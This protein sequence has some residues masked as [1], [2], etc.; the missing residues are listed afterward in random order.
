[1]ILPSRCFMIIAIDGPG[2]AGKSSTAKIIAEKLGFLY[3]D[4]GAMYRALAYYTIELGL[5]IEDLTSLELVLSNL[6]INFLSEGHQQRL[7]INNLDV[8]DKIRTPD[9]SNLASRIATLRPVR[10]KLVSLQRSLAVN[11]HVIMDGRDIGTVVFPNAEVK[12]YLTASVEERS[13]RRYR[14]MQEKG[15]FADLAQI[16]SDLIWRDKNDAERTES[17]LRKAV[18]AIALD[19]TGMSVEKQVEVMLDLIQ[20]AR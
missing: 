14:E 18:D 15:E 9:V 3:L 16:T 11:N 17:P 10:E 5:K 7:F 20:K 1:M 4:T 6:K 8:T 13:L 12:F 2:A 19:T